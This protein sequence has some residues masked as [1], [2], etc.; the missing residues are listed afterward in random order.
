LGAPTASLA[1]AHELARLVYQLGRYGMASVEQ[2]EAASAAPVRER[3]GRPWR[4]R[5]MESGD[6]LKKIEPAAA[7]A[8]E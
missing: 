4:R 8:V 3:L 5:A 1:A 6:G 7:S 2:T